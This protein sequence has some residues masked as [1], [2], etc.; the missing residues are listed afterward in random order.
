M[1]QP[2]K[3]RFRKQQKGRSRSRLVETRGTTLAFG[4]F[5]LQALEAAWV[6]A[7]QIEA[8]RKAISHGM[9]REG[10]MWIRVFPDKPVTKLPPEVTLGGGK[11]EVD[12]YV[13]PVK[14]GRI[15]FEVDGVPE[16][17][18]FPALRNAGHKLPVKT[19]IVTK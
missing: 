18:A 15:L 16:S 14:P 2:K 13:F 5:G 6:T 19:K 10:K 9:E 1:L 7:Q 11:G 12:H 3:Q 4:H 8:A 17:V